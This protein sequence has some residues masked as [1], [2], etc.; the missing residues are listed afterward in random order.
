MGY[1]EKLHIS[2]VRQQQVID[3]EGAGFLVKRHFEVPHGWLTLWHRFRH[4][5]WRLLHPCYERGPQ[6]SAWIR[7]PLASLEH[8]IPPHPSSLTILRLPTHVPFSISILEGAYNRT[9]V[10]KCVP[11]VRD[12][13]LLPAD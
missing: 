3:F 1:L 2:A 5:V 9:E 4:V 12:A 11:Y 6:E 10:I 7:A 13:A 8:S